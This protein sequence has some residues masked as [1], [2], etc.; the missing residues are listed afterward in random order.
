MQK[1]KSGVQY[2]PRIQEQKMEL[3]RG[4]QPE[5]RYGREPL[6]VTAANGNLIDVVDSLESKLGTV[7]G[8]LDRLNIDEFHMDWITDGMNRAQYRVVAGESIA[9]DLEIVFNGNLRDQ[10]AE[11]RG[12]DS[13]KVH[14]SIFESFAETA[15]NIEL[16]EGATPQWLTWTWE[17]GRYAGK[18]LHRRTAISLAPLG[19]PPRLGMQEFMS[20][21]GND[22]Y[23]EDI[24]VVDIK[25]SDVSDRAVD[26]Y[27]TSGLP[28]RLASAMGN[29]FIS[30]F[31][32]V[33]EQFLEKFNGHIR[34]SAIRPFVL[35]Q[36]FGN[37]YRPDLSYRE[38]AASHPLSLEEF[39]NYLEYTTSVGSDTIYLQDR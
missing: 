26:D 25:H 14:L 29:Y 23:G 34:E 39:A 37:E 31:Y 18:L 5:H 11:A 35:A 4:G 28:E 30:H 9:T 15:K 19:V 24:N 12:A 10:L 6:F 16:P 7:R 22:I 20:R 33:S 17:M 13:V 21:L 36:E 38:L 27:F 32:G 1:L 8:A 3:I 2:I